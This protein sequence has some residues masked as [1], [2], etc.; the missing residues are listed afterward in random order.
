[1][2]CNP[3]PKCI[4]SETSMKYIAPQTM[5]WWLLHVA[6]STPPLSCCCLAAIAAIAAAAAGVRL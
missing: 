5:S 4:A 1:M 3:M 2:C 6:T